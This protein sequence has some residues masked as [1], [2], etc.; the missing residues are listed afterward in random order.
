MKSVR[1][2]IIGLGNIGMR[3]AT[4]VRSGR[5]FGLPFVCRMFTGARGI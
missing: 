4:A 2:G 1:V 3:H 5:V